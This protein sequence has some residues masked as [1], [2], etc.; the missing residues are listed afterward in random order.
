MASDKKHKTGRRNLNA[1]VAKLHAIYGKRLKADDYTALMNCT[2]VAEAADY[3]KHNTYY[4]RILE[5]VDTDNIHRGN[6]ENILRRGFYENYFR[7]LSFEKIGGDE[8]YNFITVKTEIEEILICI[9]HINAGT[10]DHINTLPIYMNRFTCFDLM[11]LAHVRSFS[12]L[13]SLT[14][15]TP[16]HDI[17]KGF[18]PAPKSDGSDGIIDYAR[19]E[20]ALRTYYTRRLAAS[21]EGFGDETGKKLRSFIGT[22]TDM[23]NIINAYRMTR[24]FHADEKDIKSRMI[25]VYLK[26]P[27]KR[28]DELFGA[29]DEKEFMERFSGSYYGR[30]IADE[31]IEIKDLEMALFRLRYVQTKR[32]FGSAST[33]AVC[34]YTFQ[35]LLEIELNNIIRIIEGIRY[36]LPVKEISELLIC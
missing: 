27:E 2:S 9:S 14:E 7:I 34:F 35:N 17:L 15:K 31:G 11:E 6:L 3:L 22:Q 19:C 5:G 25:P 20:L 18:A 23:I 16:Y 24:Y 10:D 12:E 29:A 33:A 30:L 8:F 36:S 28:L 4:S 1:T 32:A 21:A 26:L 13:L